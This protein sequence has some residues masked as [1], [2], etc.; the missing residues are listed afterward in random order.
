MSGK[1]LYPEALVSLRHRL[2]GLPSRC[3]ER[4]SI[5][6][7]TANLYDVSESTLYRTL[8]EHKRP[9]PLRRSDRGKPRVLPSE[10]METYCEVIAAMKIRSSNKKSLMCLHKSGHT[11]KLI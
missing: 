1:R 10:L 9:K 5:M 7:E 11:V 2:S 6:Q 8:K 4:R 3:K